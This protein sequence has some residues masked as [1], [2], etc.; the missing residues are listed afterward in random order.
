M[1]AFLKRELQKMIDLHTHTNQSDGTLTPRELLTEA[2]RLGLE[3]LA[4]TDHDT[5]AGYDQAAAMR[6][7]IHLIC[8][9]ELSTKYEGRSIHLLAYFLKRD[10]GAEFR[11]WVAGLIASRRQR[12]Q[13]LIDK[14]RH[15]G[16]GITL[17][18]VSARGRGMIGRPHFAAVMLEKG[19]VASAQQAFDEYLGE[20]GSCFTAR[21][22]VD[23][24]EAVAR[25]VTAGGMPVLAHPGRI[26]PD[27]AAFAN[28]LE[29]MQ[30][31][32]LRGL[33]AFHSEHSPE[34]AAAWAALARRYSL[35]VTGGS[36]F[37][38]AAKPGIALGAGSI[39]FTVLEELRRVA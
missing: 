10:P 18:E 23:F 33:E 37:H 3:A 17:E 19:Y 16:V 2:T 31:V 5:F 1:S 22:E 7:G 12:N 36:D 26:L 25:I 27:P 13:E 30:K 24:S 15:A 14:L 29:R 39:P 4:I 8:G 35:A 28:C 21:D 11:T 34:Q 6:T 9:I 20:S 38:G 32:G